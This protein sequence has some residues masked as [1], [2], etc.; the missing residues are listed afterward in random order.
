LQKVVAK[1][2]KKYFK[3]GNKIIKAVDGVDISIK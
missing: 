3:T 2:L 1:D